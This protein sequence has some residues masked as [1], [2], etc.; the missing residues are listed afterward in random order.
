MT[1]V[2][3]PPNAADLDRWNA[4]AEGRAELAAWETPQSVVAALL[5]ER[6]RTSN[7]DAVTEDLEAQDL[8]DLLREIQDAER[9][10]D[11]A[12]SGWE[13]VSSDLGRLA[14]ALE[15]MQRERAKKGVRP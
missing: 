15:T 13:D 7:L 9:E 12:A 2:L 11:R 4:W 8:K 3:L 10:A 6:P 14:R 5:A 1:P